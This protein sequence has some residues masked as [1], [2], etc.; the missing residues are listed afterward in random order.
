MGLANTIAH[1]R[2]EGREREA[3][4]IC[5]MLPVFG[6]SGCE[7]TVAIIALLSETAPV[8]RS[9]PPIWMSFTS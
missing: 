9:A 6:R 3:E 5:Q 2:G 1:Y 4:L 7:V 8:I